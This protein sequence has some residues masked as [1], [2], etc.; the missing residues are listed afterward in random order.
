MV[1]GTWGQYVA[2]SLRLQL[3]SHTLL[4]STLSQPFRNPFENKVWE[5]YFHKEVCSVV[6][7]VDYV[8]ACIYA[9]LPTPPLGLDMTQGQF[10]SGV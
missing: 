7:I 1:R 10:L 8:S 2:V 5:V 3:P 6:I 4:T 9:Y